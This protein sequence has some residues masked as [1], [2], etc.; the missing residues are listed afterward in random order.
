MHYYTR[1]TLNVNAIYTMKRLSILNLLL[2]DMPTLEDVGFNIS[3]IFFYHGNVE[4]S[5]V[6]LPCM[7][8]MQECRVHCPHGDRFPSQ[9][10]CFSLIKKI[11]T[12]C[13]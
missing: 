11:I 8:L 6:R 12:F 2:A 7:T 13:K 1:G 3:F 10:E 5:F 4:R 9:A